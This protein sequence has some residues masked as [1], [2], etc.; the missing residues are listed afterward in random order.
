LRGWG[1]PN[2]NDWR[3]NLA[4]CLLCGVPAFAGV[5]ADD[6]IIANAGAIANAN[7]PT[8]ILKTSNFEHVIPSHSFY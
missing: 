8:G 5:I 1:S 6:G 7:F 4:L 2:S 3:K